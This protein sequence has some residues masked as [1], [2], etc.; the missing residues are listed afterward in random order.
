MEADDEEEALLICRQYKDTI[1]LMVTD[2]VMP[3]ISGPELAKRLVVIHPE[4]KVLYMSG[5][6]DN[7]IVHH[8]VLEEGYQGYFKTIIAITAVFM[9]CALLFS[10]YLSYR[11]S[12][13]AA[14]SLHLPF[15]HEQDEKI[16]THLH[17]YTDDILFLTGVPPVQGIIGAREKG[18]YDSKEQTSYGI[19]VNRWFFISL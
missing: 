19:W 6:A 11:T 17:R 18:G 16:E 4:M 1:H 13:S 15:F 9:F 2:V 7:A 14:E 5:Y 8:G 10:I 3:R 12:I